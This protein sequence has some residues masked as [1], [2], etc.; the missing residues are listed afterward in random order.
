M[1]Y[2]PTEKIISAPVSIYDVQQC[3]GSGRNDVGGLI[4]N[5]NIN[6]WAKYKP[7]RSATIDTVKQSSVIMPVEEAPQLLK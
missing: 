7:V 5:V 3:F 2:N 1:S 4:A 6:K